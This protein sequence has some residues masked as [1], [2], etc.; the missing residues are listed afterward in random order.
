MTV[1]IFGPAVHAVTPSEKIH[2][3]KRCVTLLYFCG[4]GR[5]R[6]LQKLTLCEPGCQWCTQMQSEQ[7][8]QPCSPNEMN[9]WQ[10]DMTGSRGQQGLGWRGGDLSTSRH[11][12]ICRSKQKDKVVADCTMILFEN[13]QLTYFLCRVY[14]V[15]PGLVRYSV[16]VRK[17]SCH[18]GLCSQL[19]VKW[20][21]KWS[22]KWPAWPSQAGSRPWAL[23]FR[24]SHSIFTP[25]M[26]GILVPSVIKLVVFPPQ[27]RGER[28][29]CPS[30]ARRRKPREPRHGA[31]LWG[32][33]QTARDPIQRVKWGRPVLSSH[34]GPLR[35]GPADHQHQ[36][37]A[38]EEAG[39]QNSAE[40]GSYRWGDAALNRLYSIHSHTHTHVT[41]NLSPVC[42]LLFFAVK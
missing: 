17:M 38:G 16:V 31:V 5:Q 39:Q 32:C 11:C 42:F 12:R 26:C 1:C 35:E 19:P 28:G 29:S 13:D 3:G 41:F 27:C 37:W 34:T 18:D 2:F 10:L 6:P 9:Q 23:T 7:Q 14:Y 36:G 22:P 21:V 40:F 25:L 4:D 15:F 8:A 30:G 24:G 20:S 33:T